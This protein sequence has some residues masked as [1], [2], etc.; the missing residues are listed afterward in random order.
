MDHFCY[1]I[2]QRLLYQDFG[3]SA[4]SPYS[5][6]YIQQSLRYRHLGRDWRHHGLFPYG[7]VGAMLHL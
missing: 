6:T 7:S 4:L 2:M 1:R 5:S 3:P